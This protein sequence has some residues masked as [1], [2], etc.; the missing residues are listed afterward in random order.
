MNTY[1]L[2]FALHV[3]IGALALGSFWTAGFAR[4]GGRV[5]VFAG[6]I[7]LLAM[8]VVLGSA[9]PLTIRLLLRGVGDPAWFLLFLVVLTGTGVWNSWRAV[10]D[11]RDYARFI[12]PV[13]RVLAVLNL[14]G[15]AA[16]FLLGMRHGLPI[17]MVFSLLGVFAGT[18]M[19][20]KVRTGKP[21]SPRWWIGEHMASMIANG[22]A[23]HVAFLLVGLPKLLPMLAGPTLQ[24]IAWLGPVVVAGAARVVLGRKY[25]R[26]PAP[27]KAAAVSPAA[28]AAGRSEVA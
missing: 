7:Y 25:L 14:L 23:T 3:G 19:L 21:D 8:A 10:R 20:R 12:G 27:R 13:Y 9:V 18:A 15:G 17:L 6:R 4:K 26:A 24:H 16:V 11:K 28:S 5:H 22:I 2:V 1:T